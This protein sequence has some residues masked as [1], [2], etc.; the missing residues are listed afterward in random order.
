MLRA[1]GPAENPNGVL[2][3]A[4]VDRAPIINPNRLRRN[5]FGDDSGAP[6]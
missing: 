2:S 1:G 6:A 3:G 4:R 5:P